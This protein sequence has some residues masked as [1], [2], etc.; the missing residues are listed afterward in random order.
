MS[1]PRS[2]SPSRRPSRAGRPTNTWPPLEVDLGHVVV[3]AVDREAAAELVHRHVRAALDE[4]AELRRGAAVRPLVVGGAVAVGMAAPA[5]LT[6]AWRRPLGG[7][8]VVLRRA[9]HRDARR[10]LASAPLTG[11]ASAWVARRPGGAG[12]HGTPRL[13]RAIGPVGLRRRDVARRRGPGRPVAGRPPPD[14]GRRGGD[15]RGAVGRGGGDSSVG[16]TVAGIPAVG[17]GDGTS[18]SEGGHRI[19]ISW[20][21]AARYDRR[22]MIPQG[23]AKPR[24]AGRSA[25]D[26]GQLARRL[27]ED[28][29]PVLAA[30][31]DVLDPRAVRGRRGRSRAR[32]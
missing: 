30:H 25:G 8:A 28:D 13:L 15:G 4:P 27:V 16:P 12:R 17:L 22:P 26:D 3:G 14:V 6:G 11:A 18:P 29:R 7:A 31:D 24:P 19:S 9:G 32:R 1:P 2:S 20:A 21:A 5:P 10:R 23:A